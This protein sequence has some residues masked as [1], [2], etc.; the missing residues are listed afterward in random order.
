MGKYG[1]FHAIRMKKYGTNIVCGVSKGRHDK[2]ENIPILNSVEEA[3][4]KYNAD[5]SIVFV[6]AIYAKGAILESIDAG[7]EKIIV[8]TEHIPQY[9]MLYLCHVARKKG[10]RIIGPNCPG[11]ILPGV[12]KIGIMPEGAFV[13]GN[14]AVISKSGTLMYE[15][16]NY[17]SLYSTG[18]KVAIGL[19]GDPISGTSIAEAFDWLIDNKVAKVRIIGELGGNEEIEGIKHA[20]NMGYSGE[21]KVFLAGRMAPKGKRMGHAGAIVRGY[22]GSVDYKENELRKLGVAVAKTIPELI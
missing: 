6:P 18:I 14:I 15:V 7:I 9:D 21:I 17:L 2:Y 20:L 12:S 3:V 5:T 4:S 16:S 8:I 1:T 22:I 13:P 10:A 19:G 11:L